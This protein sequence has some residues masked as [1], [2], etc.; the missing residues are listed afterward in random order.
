VVDLTLPIESNMAGIP[1]FKIYADNPSRVSIIS[2]MTEG[3]KEMLISNGTYRPD[4]TV[5]METAR[6]LGW[7]KEWEKRGRPAQIYRL[8]SPNEIAEKLGIK[9]TSSDVVAT[10]DFLSVRTYRQ[11]LHKQLLERRPGHYT[12]T[13]LGA[14]LGV[15]RWTTRRYGQPQTGVHAIQIELACRG[16]ID[17][18]TAEPTPAN[19]PPPLLEERA[20]PLRATLSAVLQACLAFAQARDAR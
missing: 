3:Q 2:A 7:D 12:R 19:W 5:N 11:A 16:Y 8:P 1:G 18:P 20:A 17:E 10:T 13:W 9:K 14:R 6:R 4:G 15:S